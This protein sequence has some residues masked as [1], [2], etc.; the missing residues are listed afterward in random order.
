MVG[1]GGVAIYLRCDIDCEIVAQSVTSADSPEYLFLEVTLHHTRALLGVFY[2]PHLRVDYFEQLESVLADLRTRY[3][4]IIL[5]GDFNTCLVK[6]DCRSRKLLSLFHSLFLNCLELYPTHF[7]HNGQPSLLDLIITSSP[8][9]VDSHGQFNAAAF[10]SHDLIYASF[11]IRPPKRRH[12]TLM[13]RNYAKIDKNALFDDVLNSDW[14]LVFG[15]EDV[16]EMVQAFNSII[17]TIFDKHAP[18]QVVRVK[19]FPAPWLTPDIKGVMERRNRARIRLRK[20]P[21]KIN[22]ES[23][24]ELRNRCNKLCRSARRKHIHSTIEGCPHTKMWKYLKS[25]GIGKADHVFPFNVDLNALNDYFASSPVCLDSVIKSR[26]LSVLAN[27]PCLASASFDFGK[28]TTADV[29]KILKSVTTKAVGNDGLSLDM[30]TPIQDLVAPILTHILNFSL[31]SGVFP[32]VWKQAHVE[33]DAHCQTFRHLVTPSFRTSTCM[34]FAFIP[35]RNNHALETISASAC[36][37][38]KELRNAEQ[39]DGR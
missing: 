34:S 38:T 16:N 3:E 31:S 7:P 29:L 12:K 6:R 22:S 24:I 17:L 32:A 26:T 15:A 4:H 10:S 2:S 35:A 5:M 18:L 13:L 14:E 37:V 25:L 19:H 11:K 36:N 23:Y 9:L 21:T 28:V 8:E 20:N 30:I 27:A 39:T 1:G 33:C